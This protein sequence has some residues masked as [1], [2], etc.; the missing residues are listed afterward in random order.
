MKLLCIINQ[1]NKKSTRTRS[2][3][4]K[5]HKYIEVLGEKAVDF[6]KLIVTKLQQ[7]TE[8]MTMR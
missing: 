2:C 4:I 6:R 3:H 7:K 5:P 1:P 8:L